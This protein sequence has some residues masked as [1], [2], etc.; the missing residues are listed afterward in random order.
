MEEV[1]AGVAR[2]RRVVVALRWR[3]NHGTFNTTV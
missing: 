3:A 1:K 2:R